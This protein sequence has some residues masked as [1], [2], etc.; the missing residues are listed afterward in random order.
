MD[1]TSLYQGVATVFIAQA[2][3]IDLSLTS[4]LMI[5]LTATLASIGSAGVPGAGM[6]MLVLS[7]AYQRN[8]GSFGIVLSVV[9]F[10]EAAVVPAILIF[11]FDVLIQFALVPVTAAIGTTAKGTTRAAL[12][13]NSAR[14]VTISCHGAAG[15]LRGAG[16]VIDAASRAFEL[17]A[18]YEY[19]FWEMAWTQETWPLEVN[20]GSSG[21]GPG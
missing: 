18:R 4:Q 17:S 19:A 1:G 6:V 5:V 13:W 9:A 20:S 7:V 11:C 2:L 21:T 3:G 16:A 14:S 10:G 12:G 15:P 8:L